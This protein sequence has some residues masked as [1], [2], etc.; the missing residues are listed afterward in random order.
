MKKNKTSLSKAGSYREM[1]EFWDTHDL[2]EIWEK[3]KKA[4]FDVRVESEV[5]YYPVEKT[6]SE[7]LHS[8]AKRQGVSSDT[9][10]NLWIQQKLQ[11]M[12]NI[13]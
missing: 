4:Q 3:T 5:I 6:L 8:V 9:L 2:G 12:P 7:R 11:E 13:R 10:V 1:G